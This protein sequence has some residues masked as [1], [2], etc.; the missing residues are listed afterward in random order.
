LV[1][2]RGGRLIIECQKSLVPLVSRCPG[3]ERVVPL[4][5]ELPPFDLQAPLLSLP[6]I[7]GTTLSTVPAD[8]PYLFPDPE[9]V[10]RWREELSK[11]Q[12]LKVGIAWQGNPRY[13]HDKRRSIPLKFFGLFA[14]VAGVQFI[15][16]QKGIGTEQ[17]S[18][19]PEGF[20]VLDLG[21]RLDEA[22]GPFMDTAAIMKNLDLVI[23]SDTA[24]PHLAGALGV[25]VWVAL[26]SVVDW[27]WLIDREDSPWYPTM[28]L[29]RQQDPG[30]WEPVFE[31]M[32][33][34]LK[35]RVQTRPEKR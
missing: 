10:A 18:Q 9:L 33:S 6:G 7:F 28:R 24:I 19:L 8:V 32:A 34:E 11:L 13:S 16:L 2:E 14:R 1:R 17:L 23:T 29:F 12:G 27:R 25:P 15:S 22:A 31:Q 20:R 26:A 35:V 21:D 4:G 3:I 30:K 5:S